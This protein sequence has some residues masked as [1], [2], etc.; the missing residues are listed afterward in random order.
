M[1]VPHGVVVFTETEPRLVEVKRK[2]ILELL[3]AA[4]IV[5]GETMTALK[6]LVQA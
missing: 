4:V 6:G 2:V 5:D 3:I 1:L